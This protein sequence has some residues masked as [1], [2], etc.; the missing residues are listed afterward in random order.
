ML[1]VEKGNLMGT[2]I[3][4]TAPTE[5]HDL[6]GRI[7]RLKSAWIDGKRGE[8][9]RAVEALRRLKSANA[10]DGRLG[11]LRERIALL[12]KVVRALEAGYIPLPR[13]DAERLRI[14]T[15]EL[16]LSAL[17]A[18][19]EAQASALFD[20]IRLVRGQESRSRAPWSRARRQQ[21]DPLLVGVIRTPEHREGGPTERNPYR[22]FTV[23]PGREEH[24]LLAWWRPEDEVAEEMF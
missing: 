3:V 5:Q 24:F 8:L 15:E 22:E 10:G 20:E 9:E 2:D 4:P 1:L 23:Y 18:V 17:V 11:R 16:P 21:R 14:D 12:R 13:F 7:V 19:D 6:V